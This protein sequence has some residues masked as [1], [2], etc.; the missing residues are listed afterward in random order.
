MITRSRGAFAASARRR[1]LLSGAAA[2]RSRE[3]GSREEVLEEIVPT[4]TTDTCDI[5]ITV[6]HIGDDVHVEVPVRFNQRVGYLRHSRCHRH[7]RELGVN[8]G[9][10]FRQRDVG[11]LTIPRADGIAHPKL[12]VI[13][14]PA[15]AQV[16]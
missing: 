15:V 13:R 5:V 3:A 12:D 4:L 7:P 2:S 11:L 8:A 10:I 6:E 1:F 14:E 9:E 16:L